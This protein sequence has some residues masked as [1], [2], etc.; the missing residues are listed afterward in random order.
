ML[1]LLMTWKAAA[2]VAPP[3]ER[4]LNGGFETFT[5]FWGSPDGW[6][7][8][9]TSPGWIA[10]STL[11]SPFPFSGGTSTRSVL[12]TDDTL[13]NQA[14]MLLQQFAPVANAFDLSFDFRLGGPTTFSETWML[15]AWNSAAIQLFNLDLDRGGQFWVK[16]GNGQSHAL[17]SPS[18]FTWY[19]VEVHG[20]I[21]T[22]TYSG[23]VTPFGGAS[24]TWNNVPFWTSLAQSMNLGDIRIVESGPSGVLSP[25]NFDNL[26]IVPVP[27]PS[28]WILTIAGALVAGW[29]AWRR[30]AAL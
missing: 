12:M 16:G 24:F 19:H 25:V 21:D 26:S 7:G 30:R 8:V 28:V 27:E 20:S 11:V 10:E 9:Q 18:R 2:A 4:L 14:P 22:A 23:T 3:G 15:T 1:F 5:G 13:Q 29:V 6:V 17:F